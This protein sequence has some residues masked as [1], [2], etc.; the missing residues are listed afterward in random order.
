VTL[1][2]SDV[3]TVD[4]GNLSSLCVGKNVVEVDV[5]VAPA[6]LMEFTERVNQVLS[7]GGQRAEALL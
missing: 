1:V 3:V 4:D 5:A 7:N 6:R 2:K